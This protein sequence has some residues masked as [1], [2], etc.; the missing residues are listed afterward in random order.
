MPTKKPVTKAQKKKAVKTV[1]REYKNKTLKHGGT[2]K[3]V[4]RKDVAIA[5]AL[6]EAGMSKKQ[7]KKKKI[8]KKNQGR[9][10]KK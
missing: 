1:M 4:K 6:S 5:I 8:A 2:G 9:K 10:R 7:G 3:T